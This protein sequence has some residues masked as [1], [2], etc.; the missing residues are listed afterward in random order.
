[1]R[2]LFDG[3]NPLVGRRT[4]C[5]MRI[6]KLNCGLLG[7][8]PTKPS[9]S[10]HGTC[11]TCGALMSPAF[12]RRH[13]I[14]L[15]ADYERLCTE[16]R[17]LER[18]LGDARYRKMMSTGTPNYPMRVGQYDYLVRQHVVLA[19]RVRELKLQLGL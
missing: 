6:R 1:L 17:R 8:R 12:Y 11:K 16:L 2:R 3:H 7:H 4:V 19:R 13:G 10:G 15:M 14:A 5:G 18:E 9:K